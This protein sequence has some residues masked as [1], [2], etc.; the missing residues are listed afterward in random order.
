MDTAILS[1]VML[2]RPRRYLLE[3]PALAAQLLEAQHYRLTV[4]QASTGYGKSTALVSALQRAPLELFWY[5]ITE[6]DRDPLVFLLYLVHAFRVKHPKFGSGVLRQ[7]QDPAAGQRSHQAIVETLSNELVRQLDPNRPAILVLDDYHLVNASVEVGALVDH[8][9][10]VLPPNTHLVLATR[11]RPALQGMQQWKV[12]GELLEVS[13]HDLAF[14]PSE[15]EALFH[16]Q[17]G[18]TLSDRQVARLAQETEGWVIALQMIWQGLQSGVASSVDQIL[19]EMA[20]SLSDLFSYLAQEVLARQSLQVQ[21]F[22]LYTSVLRQLDGP[23]CDFLLEQQGSDEVLRRFDEEGFFLVRVGD[24]YRYHHLFHDF[25]RQQMAR[26]SERTQVLHRRAAGYFGQ[27]NDVE[28]AV[29][30]WLAAATSHFPSE[31]EYE[32]AVELMVQV[33]EVLVQ[34]GRL[35]TM[36]E[37]VTALPLPVLGRQPV[38]MYRMGELC[39]FASRFDEALAWYEQARERYLA[40]RD[41]AG[42]SRALR[43]QAAV[44]LDTVRPLKAES[45]LQEAVMLVDGQPD[46]EEQARL[47]EL[48]AENM[49]NR[50]KW[51]KAEELLR[52]AREL[53]IEGPS[54][55]DL[56]VRVLLR[57]GRLD[58]ARALLEERAA[59]ER[60]AQQPDSFRAPR[61]HRE[62]LL[63][64][65]LLYSWMGQA[66]QALVT[67]Q[68]GI[69]VGRRLGSP[70]VEAVGFMRLGHAWQVTERV[71]PAEAS[72]RALAC[73]ERAMEIGERLAVRRTKAE[74]LWGLCRLHGYR[75]ELAAAERSAREGIETGLGAGD[76]WI[77]A[78]TGVTLGISYVIAGRDPDADYWLDLSAMAFQEC[79][80]PFG[81]AVARL[82]QSYSY[83]R[84]ELTGL[85]SALQGL[86]ALLKEH[87]YQFLLS[88]RTFLGLPDPAAQVPLLIRARQSGIWP[89]FAG[90]MLEQTGLPAEL[91]FHPG[92]TLRVHALGRF[93][94]G[95][96]D[97]PISDGEWRREK[98]RQLFQLLLLS[99]HESFVPRERIAAQLWP[100]ADE[101]AAE[102]QFKV[103]LNAL[104]RAL[105]PGRP[106]RTATLFVQRRGSA[107]GLNPDAPLWFD[108]DVF[109]RLVAQ[110]EQEADDDTALEAYRQALALYH[111]DLLPDHLYE[112]WCRED[113]ERLRRVFL[114]ASTRAA[115]ILAARGGPE[116]AAEAVALCERMLAA[117]NCWE[118]AYQLLMRIYLGQENRVKALR[119]YERCVSCLREELDVEP[120]PETVALYRQMQQ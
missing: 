105:E 66:E 82:W 50:G 92:Y 5:S 43:G 90:R 106:P 25:L 40:L 14:S 74:A 10:Q 67:A 78:L 4:V 58:E 77:V 11:Q 3:R 33:S 46:R 2:P 55:A 86:F 53:R 120:A 12:K 91:S 48:M 37:W 22:L 113:Q 63:L 7:I 26:D 93:A 13:Q 44:Y 87:N 99:R 24:A 81:Q 31:V 100:E 49:T 34:R 32:A 36:S 18:V 101:E 79:G 83:L 114:N 70:F 108:V 42:A 107:Y 9:L 103:S 118:A 84:R 73:Y 38:L 96:G 56:D 28:G 51:D 15:V 85:G 75:G 57:T 98:A 89:A 97:D 65:S 117:D 1:K 71:E 35:D 112:D 115:E 116:A 54:K 39:R 30:H 94:V 64:L 17:Y 45:L 6:Q 41:V 59:A 8:F 109:E 68:E 69:A 47:L 61:A 80:D 19:D 62:T 16:R 29:Y 119:T 60:R 23:V 111:G 21:E 88:Q 110:A 76:E 95:R 104:Q 102:R 72:R 20:W 52:Q 27:Q